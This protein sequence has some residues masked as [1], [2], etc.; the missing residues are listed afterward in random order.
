[1][2]N[3]ILSGRHSSLVSLLIAC[4]SVAGASAQ[5]ADRPPLATE[6]EVRNAYRV[7]QEWVTAYVEGDDLAHRQLTHERIRQWYDRRRWRDIMRGARARNGEL[8]AFNV[9][10]AG[11]VDA[12]RLPCTEMGHCYRRGLQYAIFAIET[13]YE[14]ASPPQPE[15]A[16][17]AMTDQ[18]WRFA[19]GTILNRPMGE[20]LLILDRADERRYRPNLMMLEDF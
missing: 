19:G 11:P 20:S 5:S 9:T 1:M 13:E 12:E 6:A 10:M 18:G 15:F 7:L 14:T 4:L 17:M 3:R 8:V 2:I 16:V